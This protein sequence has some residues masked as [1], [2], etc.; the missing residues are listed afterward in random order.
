MGRVRMNVS[1]QIHEVKKRTK[2]G[3]SIMVESG[4]LGDTSMRE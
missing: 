1:I 3:M 4:E 2:V